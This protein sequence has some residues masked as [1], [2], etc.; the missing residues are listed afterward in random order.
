MQDDIHARIRRTA[1][2]IAQS[3][4]ASAD[5]TIQKSYP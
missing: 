3:A 1:S 4:G 5:V 2:L